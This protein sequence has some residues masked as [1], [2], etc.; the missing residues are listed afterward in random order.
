[1]TRQE[2]NAIMN[3]VQQKLKIVQQLDAPQEQPQFPTFGTALSNV[4]KSLYGGM[5]PEQ[6]RQAAQAVYRQEGI[7]FPDLL[8]GAGALPG[9]ILSMVR[10]VEQNPMGAAQ[11]VGDHAKQTYDI[12]NMLTNPIPAGQ[13]M[14]ER[15]QT[16]ND[17]PMTGVMDAVGAAGFGTSMAQL[18]SMLSKMASMFSRTR[19]VPAVIAEAVAPKATQAEMIARMIPNEVKPQPKL[20]NQQVFDRFGLPAQIVE[21]PKALSLKD[22]QQAQIDE[23]LATNPS[24]QLPPR[25]ILPEDYFQ[26][27]P[28]PTNVQ[29]KQEK[30]PAILRQAIK[31]QKKPQ[32]AFSMDML[33]ENFPKDRAAL[34]EAKGADV[35][36]AAGVSPRSVTQAATDIGRTPG[37]MQSKNEGLLRPVS[38]VRARLDSPQGSNFVRSVERAD[39]GINLYRG[40][41]HNELKKTLGKLTKEEKNEAGMLASGQIEDANPKIRGIVANAGKLMQRVREDLID[42]GIEVGSATDATVDGVKVYFP[43]MLKRDI[44]MSIQSDV[45]YLSK[46]V[47]RE[48]TGE[49]ASKSDAAIMRAFERQAKRKLNKYTA[50][51]I[52]HAQKN[53]WGVGKLLRTLDRVAESG[54][55]EYMF[56]NID[57]HRKVPAPSHFF[58][59]DVS[60]VYTRYLN[61][62]SKRI[63][64]QSNFGDA[65][66]GLKNLVEEIYKVD[67]AQGKTAEHAA[68]AFLGT[69]ERKNA[70]TPSAQKL[71]SHISGAT[72]GSVI[73]T[74]YS[75]FVNTLQ[76]IVSASKAGFIP[77]VKGL[78][79]FGKGIARER[80]GMGWDDYVDSIRDSGAPEVADAMELMGGKFKGRTWTE[81]VAHKIATPFNKVNKFNQ[82]VSAA[83]G[84]EHVLDL[85]SRANKGDALSRRIL[86]EDFAID[87]AK[88]LADESLKKAMYRF[89]SDTQLTRNV[90]RDP[91]W[92]NNPKTRILGLL[93]RFNF[94]QT[95]YAMK[96]LLVKEVNRGNYKP[97]VRLLGTGIV[98]GDAYIWAKNKMR[99]MAEGRDITRDEDWTDYQRYLNDLAAV[100]TLG[101][102][103]NMFN[104]QEVSKSKRASDY[105]G[106]AVRGV[107]PFIVSKGVE[108]GKIAQQ[109]LKDV[110]RLGV[111]GSLRENAPKGIG[112]FSPIGG[113]VS[114][115]MRSDEE[116]KLSTSA[117]KA[118]LTPKLKYL[119]LNNRDDEAMKRIDNWNA[120]HPESPINPNGDYLH[121]LLNSR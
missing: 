41:T 44:A 14:Q 42:A 3:E 17:N 61:G 20:S 4:G 103:S 40:T 90:M 99:G 76:T 30:I 47:Q 80:F 36:L 24:E 19:A 93:Q 49:V 94:R 50:E 56:G 54:D 109:G 35:E 81:N 39:E 2:Y 110:D 116:L 66:V 27:K 85:Y 63:G 74:G 59:T 69:Y 82:Y 10:G 106:N 48:V 29:P 88:P 65:N 9:Q 58:E 62:A 33:N 101:I 77:S 79:K 7:P 60:E 57:K 118:R 107:T 91:L 89:S 12:A 13:A 28:K 86:K 113:Q 83:F 108:A 5:E 105:V 102:I 22:I 18:P 70:L 115:R 112:F 87:Y 52:D 92:M 51:W 117:E 1:M 84:R 67:A 26:P 111:G 16:Y 45:D 53:G 11:A 15:G 8:A 114:Q 34:N 104:S 43:R 55:L 68:E 73:G 78:A 38:S 6:F 121:M 46:I 120:K 37:M 72:L 95:Q 32:E 97:F 119:F 75:A 100:G 98:A 71:A 25:S 31:E 21:K 64:L 96:D 23:F